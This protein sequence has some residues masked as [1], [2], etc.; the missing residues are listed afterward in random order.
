MIP[1][2]RLCATLCVLLAGAVMAG[3]AKFAAPPKAAKAGDRVRIEFEVSQPTDVAVFI[4]DAAGRV[5]RHLVAGRLGGNPP[6]PLKANS[7]AQSIEWDGKGDYG[8]EPGPGPFRARVALGLGAKFDRVLMSDP[9]S[10]GNVKSLAVGADGTLYVCCGF[11][12]EVPNWS[13]ERIIALNRDGVYERTVLP[14]PANLKKEEV[15]GYGVYELDGRPAPLLHS[16]SQ[17][18]FHSGLTS[19]KAGM[20]L[21]PDG[22]LLRPVGGYMTGAPPSLSAIATSGAAGWG[23]EAGPHLLPEFK[24]VGFPRP[25]I[26]ASS[27]GKWAYLAGANDLRPDKKPG[28]VSLSCVYRVKLPDR[29]PAEPFFGKPEEPGNDATRLSTHPR[30]L[31]TDGK[32]RLFIAD[33]GNDRVAVVGESDGKLLGSLPVERPDGVA[34]DPATGAVYVTRLLA[35][36][37][38]EL[39]KLKSWQQPDLVAKLSI[40][41]EGNTDFPWVMAL[42]ATEKPPVLWLGSDA[43]SLLRVEDAGDKFVSRAVNSARFGN[44]AFVDISLDRF[45]PDREVYVRCGQGNW[46][47]FNEQTGETTRLRLELPSAAGSCLTPGPDGNLYLPAYPYHLLRYSRD[48][49]PLPWPGGT[50]RYPALALGKEGKMNPVKGLP[51][52][53]YVPVS[54][55]FMTHTLGIRHDGHIFML[56]PGHA[57]DRPPKML[58]EYLPTGERV[59]KPIV[60]KVSDAAIGP[61]FDP[62]GNIYIA[63]QVKPVGQPYP[64]EFVKLFGDLREE[65]GT[66]SFSAQQPSAPQ[67]GEKVNVPFSSRRSGLIAGDQE[68]IATIYGSIVKFPPTGGMIAFGDE[69]P[70]KGEPQLDPAAKS[71][72]AT[73]FHGQRLH[74]VQVT[75][76]EWLKMG[77]SH[78]DLVYCNC[79]NTRF[80]VDEFG[81]VWYPDLGRFRV[82]VL[83]TNGNEVT[84]FGGYGNTESYGPASKEPKL[85]EPDIALAWLIG[86]AATDRFAYMGDSMNRR[87]L[88]AKLVYAAE[89]TCPIP[90]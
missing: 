54:M 14:W 50:G 13:G 66:F 87:L 18:R 26:A 78:V 75:G 77:I 58:I 35:R 72:Q 76:A 39:V 22:V 31:A 83:D 60:W 36:Q 71:V 12:A 8:K 69:N 65:K 38:M 1:R 63:E 53:L 3:E 46:F 47:C 79:E 55:G 29:A 44:S 9:Q 62:Q 28:L 52:G 51:H 84:H 23:K 45:R 81:R 49:K 17:R 40:K 67:G 59:G 6:K 42:D 7:L 5:V 68:Q 10:I 15:A 19:R 41:V 89:E 30:G 32:G 24:R 21:T 27:D 4:E 34:V 20:A 56:E 37:G 43:G 82:C 73:S 85:A 57:G 70:F 86:V 33:Q 16:L 25:F 48:G 90:Q 11:G 80:D 2:S 61:K 74:P 88:R 64:E